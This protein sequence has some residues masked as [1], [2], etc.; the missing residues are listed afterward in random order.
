MAKGASYSRRQRRAE[1]RAAGF[2]KI[3]NMYG[4]MSE[5]GNAWYTKMREDGNNY[6]EQYDKMIMDQREEQ[7][8]LRLKGDLDSGYYGLRNTWSDMGYNQEEV[9]K[10]EEAWLLTTIK[11][12]T[13]RADRRQAK[14]LR[15]EAQESRA[16]RVNAAG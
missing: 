5:Q 10:L 13:Y 14:Q 4:R 2:L 8:E 6:A 1:F 11:S 9:S 7:L 16:A 3:K 15:K 12:E